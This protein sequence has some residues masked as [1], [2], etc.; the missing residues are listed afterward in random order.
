[1]QLRPR[2]VYTRNKVQQDVEKILELYRRKGR[3]AA[4]VDPKV[5][6]LPQNRVDV[7]FEISEGSPTY[8]RTIN[9]VGNEA[10][11]DDDLLGVVLTREERWWRFLTSNDTY[12]PDRMNYD[13]ELLRQHYVQ[14]GYADFE[15]ISARSRTRP[16]PGKFLHDLHG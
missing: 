10:F 3:F 13:R 16:E 1:M 9:F 15:V 2:V 8:V 12:D 14:E 6:E 4:R 11:D 7:V 5:I